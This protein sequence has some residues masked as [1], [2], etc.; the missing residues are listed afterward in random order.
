MSISE[1]IKMSSTMQKHHGEMCA[2]ISISFPGVVG[3]LTHKVG[4]QPGKVS[5]KRPLVHIDKQLQ[6]T[7][8]TLRTHV[9]QSEKPSNL[10]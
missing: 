3:K 7:A 2:R 8:K 6:V 4:K 1:H 9:Y 5:H 10:H